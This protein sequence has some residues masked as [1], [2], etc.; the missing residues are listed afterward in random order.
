MKRIYDIGAN[1]GKKIKFLTELFLINK[2][3]INRK[4]N[5]E[6]IGLITN[7]VEVINT[8]YK[9]L[10]SFFWFLIIKSI[11][12]NVETTNSGLPI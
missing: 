8:S 10:V 12:I 5:I 11:N 1:I 9:L 6:E 4:C 2:P 3:L 7:N